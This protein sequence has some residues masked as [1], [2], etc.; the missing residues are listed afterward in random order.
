MKIQ[1]TLIKCEDGVL[2]FDI[3]GFTPTLEIDKKYNIDVKE[4]KKDRSI[5]Q[6][7]RLWAIIGLIE[8]ETR[9]T[10]WEI[11]AEGLKRA[12]LNTFI[13][14]I[15]PTVL[16]TL[17]LSYRNVEVL[18]QVFNEEG[19]ENLICKCY[20]GSSKFK[21]KEMIQLTD[22]FIDWAISLGIRIEEDER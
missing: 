22:C 12:N 18:D 16:K 7:A 13:I 19:K 14:K 5:E 10:K 8:E 20:T 6:N 4:Y 9:S 11:Y 2:L 17:K 1:A 21:V 3:D 15:V